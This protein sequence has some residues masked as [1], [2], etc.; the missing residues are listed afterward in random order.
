MWIFI[1]LAI[2]AA[3]LFVRALLAYGAKERQKLLKSM[4]SCVNQLVDDGLIPDQKYVYPSFVFIVDNQNKKWAFKSMTMEDALTF[5]FKDLADYSLIED[6]KTIIGSNISAV[7]ADAAL[8]DT[9]DEDAASSGKKQKN[10]VC[11]KMEIQ[12]LLNQSSCPELVLSFPVLRF[13][14]NGAAYK[15]TFNLANDICASL[16]LIKHN[17]GITEITN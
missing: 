1:L 4:D 7:D 5:S 17:A 6:G 2:A 8:A 14:K 12:M 11:N 10:E 3:V 9:V 15:D 16:A 13:P